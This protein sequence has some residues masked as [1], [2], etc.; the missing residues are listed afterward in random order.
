MR[1]AAVRRGLAAGLLLH[2]VCVLWLWFHWDVALRRTILVWLDIPVSLV[3]LGLA[4]GHLLATSLILGGLQWGA[5][6]A[7]LSYLAG[8]LSQ[9]PRQD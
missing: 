5:V 8:R 7:G 6:A 4:S 1:R 3:Y 9:P 2:T